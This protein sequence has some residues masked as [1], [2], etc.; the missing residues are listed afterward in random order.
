MVVD[1]RGRE[2][3]TVWIMKEGEVRVECWLVVLS[4]G[5]NYGAKVI[6]IEKD[7]ELEEGVGLGVREAG[8]RSGSEEVGRWAVR[9]VSRAEVRSVFR[10]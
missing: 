5:G 6:I 1:G 9:G 4:F 10:S 2:E 7:I 3:T 8:T